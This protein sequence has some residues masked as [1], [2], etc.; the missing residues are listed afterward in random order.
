MLGKIPVFSRLSPIFFGD[1]DSQLAG[2]LVA[3]T[4]GILNDTETWS[5]D[6]ESE[7]EDEGEV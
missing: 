5:E 1:D 7:D 4:E 3:D 6:D 2:V